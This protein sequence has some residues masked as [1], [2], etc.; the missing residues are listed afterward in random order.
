M[1]LNVTHGSVD[2]SLFPKRQRFHFSRYIL[3]AYRSNIYNMHLSIAPGFKLYQCYRQAFMFPLGR[4]IRII[5]ERARNNGLAI[6]RN[7]SK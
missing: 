6:T 5:I 1:T 3:R 7:Q 2:V 4:L